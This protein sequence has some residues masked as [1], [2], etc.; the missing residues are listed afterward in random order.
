MLAVTAGVDVQDDRLE[1]TFVGWAR[2]GTAYMLGHHAI[3]GFATDDA[4][5][6]EMDEVLKWSFPHPYGGRLRIEATAI[7]SSD[8]DTM[9]IVYAFA[10]PR[11]GRRVFAIKGVGGS[12]PFIEQS[13]QKV[14]GG[15]LWIVGV[16]GIKTHLVS[17]LTRGSTIR[18]SASLPPVWFEQLTAERVVVR[19]SRGQPY[20]SFERIKGRRAEAL[21]C[22]V[23][24]FAVRQLVNNINWSVREAQLRNPAAEEAANRQARPDVIRSAWMER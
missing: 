16:D 20:R 2:D 18:F 13:R 12:R 24:A 23:Y 1:V 10:F 8:G 21:D 4:T 17:R 14:K 15:W 11:A 5:W 7:D 22:T 3:W 19:Y 6:C 9:E